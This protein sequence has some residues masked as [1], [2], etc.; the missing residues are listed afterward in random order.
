MTDPAIGHA[1]AAPLFEA[2]A[3]HASR[4]QPPTKLAQPANQE[5][6]R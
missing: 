4:E 2:G 6:R 1:I 3:I 5:A